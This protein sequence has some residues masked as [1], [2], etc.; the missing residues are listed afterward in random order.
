MAMRD[1]HK[2]RRRRLANSAATALLAASRPPI[3]SPVVKRH[4]SSSGICFTVVTMNI[5]EV[6]NTRQPSIVGRRPIR[7]ATLPSTIE[8]SA[9][10]ISSMDSTMPSAARSMPHS[11]AMPGEAK[12][13]ERTSNPSSAVS[14]TVIA[15]ARI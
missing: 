5:P 1:T 6:I 7:S 8:P 9:I 3:P 15:T 12:L 13:M 4:T 11:A 10:P 2:L 14:P